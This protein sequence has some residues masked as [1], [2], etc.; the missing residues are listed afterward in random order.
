MKLKCKA[1]TKSGEPCPWDSVLEGYCIRHYC[2]IKKLKGLRKS[3]LK[4]NN[5]N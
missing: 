4:N 2:V 1:K 3:K 5:W